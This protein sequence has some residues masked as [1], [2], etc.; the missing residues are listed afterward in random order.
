MSSIIR[1][2]QRKKSREWLR[3]KFFRC[4]VLFGSEDTEKQM[5]VMENA[6][7]LSKGW[8]PPNQV[9][10]DEKGNCYMYYEGEE[11]KKNQAMYDKETGELIGV[12][13]VAENS[14]IKRVF[15]FMA[16]K[17]FEKS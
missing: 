8:N 7:F 4:I 11:K 1:N 6:Q 5:K 15:S 2:A 16:E 13:R 10:T 9:F 14:E 12:D 3:N 17:H